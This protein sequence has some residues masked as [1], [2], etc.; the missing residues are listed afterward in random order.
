ML[1]RGRSRREY[2]VYAEDQF[3][4]AEDLGFEDAQLDDEAAQ[5]R[6]PGDAAT[7]DGRAP[8]YTAPP[9]R[10]PGAAARRTAGIVLLAA[11][12]MV[13]SAI[14]VHALRPVV[15][16][17]SAYR[18]SAAVPA[19]ADEVSA[20]RGPRRRDGATLPTH[21]GSVAANAATTAVP[22]DVRRS[23][24]TPPCLAI[25]RRLATGA[26]TSARASTTS[27][28]GDTAARRLTASAGGEAST[29]ARAP[30]T[31]TA[32][33]EALPAGDD[34]A[35]ASTPASPEFGFEHQPR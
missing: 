24:R 32:D 10:L 14:L 9:R 19:P 12:A 7:D 30:A 1:G 2:R 16:G 27:A 23:P 26:R 35:A 5:G 13:L 11:V 28:G 22:P 15:E 18:P 8:V 6:W 33:D 21:V 34:V 3:L 20:M 29:P 17:G 31:S 25:G 4:G